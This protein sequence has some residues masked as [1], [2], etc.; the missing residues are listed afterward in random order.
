MTQAE[1]Y[2]QLLAAVKLA[3][4]ALAVHIDECFDQLDYS[5]WNE[6][7]YAYPPKVFLDGS[8]Y[9]DMESANHI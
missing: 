6:N 1:Q 7:E 5:A 4:D 3:Q 9:Q 8:V 2:K